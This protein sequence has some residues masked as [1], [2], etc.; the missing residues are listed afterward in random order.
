MPNAVQLTKKGQPIYPRTD[1]SLVVGLQ[2]AIK[3]PPV[4]VTT[5]PT[6]SAETAGK[7]YYVGPDG[8]GE[9]ERYITSI[10]DNNTY[11]WIDLGDTSIPLPSIADNLTTDDANTAL[12]AKQG[13]VLSGQ[14]S[15][16]GAKVTGLS[17]DVGTWSVGSIGYVAN[18]HIP[19]S[20]S[21]KRLRT[22]EVTVGVPGK[23]KLSCNSTFR[24]SITVV[25]LANA[26]NWQYEQEIDLWAGDIFRVI[27]REEPDPT[28]T[29]IYQ[30]FTQ[31]Q[32]D[33][34]VASS[35][36]SMVCD[37]IA[38]EITAIHTEIYGI[39]N[40]I[41]SANANI[42]ANTDKIAGVLPSSYTVVKGQQY[43][44]D[45]YGSW[46]RYSCTDKLTAGTFNF[47]CPPGFLYCV[48]KYIS[49]SEGTQVLSYGSNSQ[50]NV[51][52]DSQWIMSVKKSDGTELSTADIGTINGYGMVEEVYGPSLDA[53]RLS[54]KDIQDN[55]LNYI[56]ANA[57][58]RGKLS[59]TFLCNYPYIAATG[60]LNSALTEG[61][62]IVISGA[63]NAPIS[64]TLSLEVK[65][66]KTASN[67][68]N[69]WTVQIANT[70]DGDVRSFIRKCYNGASWSSWVELTNQSSALPLQGKKVACFGDSITE[71]GDY[72]S[73]FATKTGAT[74]YKCG[75]GG[76]RMS[77]YGTDPY[78]SMCMSYISDCIAGNDFTDLT[79]GAQAVYERYGDDNRA[80][81]ALVAD[82]DYS[83]LDYMILFWGT[84]DYGG[85]I[86][87]GND[88]DEGHD[89]FKGAINLIVKNIL[90]AYPN[91]H[92]IFVSPFWRAT[93]TGQSGLC[94]SD[95]YTNPLGFKLPDYVDALVSRAKA[96]HIPVVNLYDSMCIG[97]YNYT[98]WLADGLHPKSGKGY[99]YVAQKIV[100]GFLRFYHE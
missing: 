25:R 41:D 97:V 11:D 39:H 23:Y 10:G 75:F 79:D 6:A 3:L 17:V 1:V 4:K 76:C 42:K 37:G 16:L 78:S 86:P 74:V 47:K 28:N 82:I 71:L 91:I 99:E 40:G 96:L 67:N 73:R 68:N 32:I 90:T 31:E 44:G 60:D 36:F 27:L 21:N 19:D 45:G 87:I 66:F 24:F 46:N 85:N 38:Q 50:N 34:E 35:G 81:A 49:D 29:N 65:T 62:Y 13:V 30:N 55:T 51:A 22:A 72:P 77:T 14:V 89:T 98:E 9:Y 18:G 69:I 43:V 54:M 61:H 59:N 88:T 33:A 80:Q 58:E 26:L 57:I 94:D 12:S 5:L 7:M 2:D 20:A 95:T 8:N 64:G 52:I 53:L 15:Q 92:L 100:S 48:Y 84:N 70:A 56:G 83:E 93:Y 63:S